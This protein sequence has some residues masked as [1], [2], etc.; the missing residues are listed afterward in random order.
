VDSPTNYGEDTGLGGEVR[1]N[2]ATLNPINP[3]RGTIIDGALRTNGG[4]L[5][6]VSTI[7]MTYGKWYA[8][9]Y[10]TAIGVE[11][12]IGL[13]KGI[14]AAQ[15]VGAISETWGYY[16]SGQKYTNASPSLYG[17]SFTTGN[18]IG[19]AYDA[20]NGI[21]TFYK[22]GVSQGIA[23]TG[24][25]DST[26]QTPY[27][28]ACSG[29]TST[30]ANDV[31]MNFGQQRWKYAPP[32]GYKALCTT[33]LITPAIKKGKAAFDAI[34]YN[35]TGTTFASPSALAFAPDLVW[36]KSRTQDISHVISDTVR[37]VGEVLCSNNTRLSS[38][39][40][41]I[42]SFNSNGFTVNTSVTANNS[43][44]LYTAWS[45]KAGGPST[46]N[47][48]GSIPSQI[49]VDSRTGLSIVNYIGTGATATIGHG[50][51]ATPS[52]I[53]NKLRS[54]TGGW[55]VYHKSTGNTGATQLESNGA[56]NVSN[57]YWNNTSPTESV[58]TVGAGL[59]VNGSAYINY[60]FAEVEGYSKFG[61][62]VG[63]SSTDGA[64]VWCSFKPKFVLIKSNSTT[65]NWTII[66]SAR[67]IY[68]PKSNPF[69]LALFPSL[70][71][72]EASNT[73]IDFLS[74]GFKLRSTNAVNGN[75]AGQS[76]IF[77]AFAE[78]PFKYSLA[79]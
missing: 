24:L 79:S 36:I 58:F 41:F 26:T 50:L 65:E 19:V 66:D 27:Y 22:D 5:I 32:A 16:S 20:D 57:V 52:F 14:Y 18:T 73:T 70:V 28:F 2:Y 46:T 74:N 47:N 4:N 54:G 23:F 6:S 31:T 62:Y 75:A 76:Y 48:D 11:S 12:S 15:Y 38:S 78:T 7:G 71:N 61:S 64:F 45:W 30:A 40:F 44:S 60:V 13:S 55:P 77:A 10:I 37:G 39:D 34:T 3:V 49:S 33:N 35:G 8:E 72:Q 17:A 29:R 63:N 56:F 21:L 9:M 69:S 25:K 59:A 43:G 68:I 1:G 67:N 42:N 53:I 51:G